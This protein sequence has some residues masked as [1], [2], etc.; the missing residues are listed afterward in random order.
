MIKNATSEGMPIRIIPFSP[1]ML[2]M[3]CEQH[4]FQD[5]LI[6]RMGTFYNS[7][8]YVKMHEEFSAL[9]D[10]LEAK[11]PDLKGTIIKIDDITASK[12]VECFDAGY[13]AGVAD[14]MTALTFN[15]LQ[16]TQTQLVDMEAIAKRREALKHD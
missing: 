2:V 4:E 9:I 6:N 14:L 15:D 1:E 12:E 5:I 16:I 8:V 13:K 10:E 11:A 3:Q 7:H